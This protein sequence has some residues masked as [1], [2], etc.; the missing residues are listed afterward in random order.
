MKKAFTLAEVLITLGIIGVVSVLTIPNIISNYQNKVLATQLKKAYAEIAQ[1]GALA[2][3]TEEAMEFKET[4][5]HNKQEFLEKYFKKAKSCLNI[6]NRVDDCFA[7]TYKMD[8]G[9]YDLQ[10]ELRDTSRCISTKSGYA[11]C[12]DEYGEGILDIN[13]KKAPNRVGKDA[14]SIAIAKDGSID[15]GYSMSLDEIVQNDWE[16]E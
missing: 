16:I 14:F 3:T 15:T 13:G 2:I 4:E 1:A 11:L 5:A 8:G 7:E 6:D 12:L 9:T 10:S